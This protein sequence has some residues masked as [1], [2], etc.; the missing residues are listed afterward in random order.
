MIDL[1][2]Q[3]N[4]SRQNS[5]PFLCQPFAVQSRANII[6]FKESCQKEKEKGRYT[7]Y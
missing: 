1:K 3:K 2:R 6:L 4:T 7:P 5:V